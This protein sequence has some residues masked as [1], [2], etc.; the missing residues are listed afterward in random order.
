MNAGE[1]GGCYIFAIGDG[2]ALNWQ[3]SRDYCESIGG[4]LTDILNQETQDFLDNSGFRLQ[5]NPE[6]LWWIGGNDIE[7]VSKINVTGN[8]FKVIIFTYLEIANS[9]VCLIKNRSKRSCALLLCLLQF[10][11][12]HT[13]T[14]LV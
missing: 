7:N 14:R 8:D 9:N 5:S 3:Q 12:I 11:M 4:F 2:T 1:L 6:I 10:F 13:L